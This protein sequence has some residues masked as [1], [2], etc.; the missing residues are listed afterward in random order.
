MRAWYDIFFP[1]PVP[2]EDEP[3]LRASQQAIEA[4]ITR[5]N[6]RGI[7]NER[8][9]LAG[10]SQGCAMT[11]QTGLRQNRKLAGLLG[12]SGS[13]PLASPVAGGRPAANQ[14]P[15]TFLAPGTNDPGRVLPRAAVSPPPPRRPGK[16]VPARH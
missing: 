7:P 15:P 5:E 14:E 9:V 8:I 2:Q 6:E 12:L 11:L 16:S 10:F 3:G 1:G 4:L 13:L